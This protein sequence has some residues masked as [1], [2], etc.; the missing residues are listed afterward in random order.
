[1]ALNSSNWILVEFDYF[2]NSG[3]GVYDTVSYVGSNTATIQTNDS[4]PLSSLSGT[5]NTLEIPQIVASNGTEIDLMQA[6]DFRPSNAPTVTP[7]NNPG[8]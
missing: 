7:G 5:V 2:S 4:L 8:A 1:M 6:F 3:A